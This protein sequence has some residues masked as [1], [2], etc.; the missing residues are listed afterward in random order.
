MNTVHVIGNIGAEPDVKVFT[1]GK[2]VGRFSVAVNNG[3]KKNPVWIPC[4]IWE[5]ACDRLLKCQALQK[6]TGRKI[7]VTGSLALNEYKQH[8][9][10]SEV[11]MRKLYVKVHSFEMFGLKQ[12]DQDMA[13]AEPEEVMPEPE[14]DLI[15]A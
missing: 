6:L 3:R 7:Q 12:Q 2:K 9:G 13:V 5:E 1:T 10:D 11:T 4:E 15:S 8:V 14:V